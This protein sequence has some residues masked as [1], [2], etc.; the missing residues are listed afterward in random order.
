MLQNFIQ[1]HRDYFGDGV[2]AQ[3]LGAAM[4]QSSGMVVPD[5]MPNIALLITT[6]SSPVLTNNEPADYNLAGGG[7]FHVPGAPKT[8]RDNGDLLRLT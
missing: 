6:S 3:Q 2:A 1:T 7:Q 5:A 8:A 4:L